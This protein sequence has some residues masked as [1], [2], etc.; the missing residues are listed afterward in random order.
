MK[1]SIRLWA[2]VLA[3]AL[4]AALAVMG[5]EH[6]DQVTENDTVTSVTVSPKTA[7]VPKGGTCQFSAVVTG[8]GSGDHSGVIWI[9]QG[10][11]ASDTSISGAGLLSV[12]EDETAAT[13][14]VRAASTVDPDKYDEA[15]VTVKASV[16]I[17]GF[18]VEDLI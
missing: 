10:D 3:A 2:A 17:T 18:T 16:A 8:T 7:D 15:T 6:P 9:I 5:C 11:K 13:L 12:A 1:R 4:A 14:T